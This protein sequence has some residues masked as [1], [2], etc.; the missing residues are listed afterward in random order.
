MYQATEI[1]HLF[2][3]KGI[4]DGKPLTNM[5]LLKMVYFAHGLHLAANDG[6]PLILDSIE[7]WQYG[8]VIPSVYYKY[9]VFR[10]ALIAN[11]EILESIGFRTEK[12]PV[13]TTD[14][15][16]VFDVT[17]ETLG[18]ISAMQLSTWTHQK[19]SAWSKV[20]ESSSLQNINIPNELIRQDFQEFIQGS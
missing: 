12:I 7:A 14:A 9:A 1:A 10:D 6:K 3:Q 16:E 18:D 20:Y 13:L 15:Q 5:K 11:E 4:T 17:W 8:P 19:G 2:V